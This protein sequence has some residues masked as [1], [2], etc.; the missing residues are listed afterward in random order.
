MFVM[1]LTMGGTDCS[2]DPFKPAIVKDRPNLE[3]DVRY[4]RYVSAA[5]VRF[6]LCFCQMCRVVQYAAF[7]LLCAYILRY[8]VHK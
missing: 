5:T 2:K 6:I 1:K 3:A 8:G 4:R 7:C